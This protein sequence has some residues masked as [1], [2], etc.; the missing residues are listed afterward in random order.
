MSVPVITTANN[1]AI[2]RP[3]GARMPLPP[4]NLSSNSSSSANPIVDGL[5]F[6]GSFQIGG[7]GSLLQSTA[8]DKLN[9]VPQALEANMGV[10][11]LLAIGVFMTLMLLKGKK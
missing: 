4:L 10:L 8:P 5:S 6:G 11:G 1:L 7:S 3:I 2:N 9:S